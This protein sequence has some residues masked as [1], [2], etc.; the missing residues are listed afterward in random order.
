MSIKAVHAERDSSDAG[1][2][3]SEVPG[4]DD[5]GIHSRLRWQ[6]KIYQFKNGSEAQEIL[7]RIH[8]NSG[9]R[10]AP[11]AVF[12]CKGCRYLEFYADEK[13]AAE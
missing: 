9:G 12:R 3:M 1:I 10:G 6:R 4:D 5:P 11:I 2:E 7:V 8:Q 13:F